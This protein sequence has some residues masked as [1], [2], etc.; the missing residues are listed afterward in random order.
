MT[1]QRDAALDRVA[2]GQK[3]VDAMVLEVEDA[4]NV[5]ARAKEAR[6]EATAVLEEAK[7]VTASADARVAALEAAKAREL[8]AC[9]DDLVRERKAR[10]AERAGLLEQM[11]GV[12]SRLAVA[13]QAQAAAEKQRED[14]AGAFASKLAD[15]HR[16]LEAQSREHKAALHAALAAAPDSACERGVVLCP[17]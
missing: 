5:S 1:A 14:D 12:Y 11:Q 3:S 16:T 6:A 8:V 4:C 10:V 7:D 13:E 2:E 9:R 15:A 17:R